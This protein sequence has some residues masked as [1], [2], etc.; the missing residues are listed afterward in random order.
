[1]IAAGLASPTT[2]EKIIPT[3]APSAPITSPMTPVKLIPK[4]GLELQD[5]TP[6]PKPLNALGR[7]SPQHHKVVEK[8]LVEEAEEAQQTA[9][10]GAEILDLR[11]RE[12]M[13]RCEVMCVWNFV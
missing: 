3:L 12:A 6:S 11:S 13:Q 1:M 4:P 10:G 7:M 9:Q 2:A 5:I 8:M